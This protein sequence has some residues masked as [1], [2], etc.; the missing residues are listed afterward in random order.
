MSSPFPSYGYQPARPTRGGQPGHG[1]YART[2]YGYAPACGP[3]RR[4]GDAGKVVLIVLLAPVALVAAFLVLC[5]LAVTGPVSVPL[6]IGA[7]VAFL[8]IRPKRG[9]GNRRPAGRPAQRRSRPPT[10][11]VY[12]YS[13]RKPRR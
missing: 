5:V 4:S 2:P 8:V 6:L 9:T 11:P 12:G 1:W 7:A 10:A 13:T 3:R